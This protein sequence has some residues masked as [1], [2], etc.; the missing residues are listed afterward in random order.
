[1]TKLISEGD[2]IKS[3]VG[4]EWNMLHPDIQR[5]FNQNPRPNN[6]YEF[7]GIMYELSCSLW[8]KLLG[9]ITMPI[10]KGALL[11]YSEKNVPVDIKVF[12][13]RDSKYVYKQRLY[14]I[15]GKKFIEFISK[16]GMHKQGEALEYVG[17]GLGM[18]LMAY[19]CDKN[20][21]FESTGYF[22]DIGLFKIPIPEILSPGKTYLYHKYIEVGKFE[23]TI[24]IRHKYLGK[25]YTQ[26]GIFNDLF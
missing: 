10:I 20:L 23:I 7:S 15:K 22:W 9:F 19:V 5:R 1:M 24:D 13:D 18:K 6:P 26:K 25:M 3:L 12:A 2:I 21:C 4:S 8:G 17:A 14:K 11:P 16:M